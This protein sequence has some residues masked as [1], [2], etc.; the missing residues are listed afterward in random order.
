MSGKDS[1][2]LAAFCRENGHATASGIEVIR[3]TGTQRPLFLVHDIHG[4]TACGAALVQHVDVD[5]PAY[6]LLGVAPHEGLPRTIEGLAR[7]CVRLMRAL[8][9][10]DPYRVVGLSFGGILAYE[11]VVQLIGED[12]G[13]EFLG[14]ID[15][16]CPT[17]LRD[18][19]SMTSVPSI[20]KQLLNCCAENEVARDSASAIALR[21]LKSDMGG[22]FEDILRRC[23]AARI[24]PEYLNDK[25]TTQIR[26]HLARVA[27]HRYAQQHYAVQKLPIPVHVFS[28]TQDSQSLAK[29]TDPLKGW[30]AILPGDQ[31]RSIR[32]S[33]SSA[34]ML[35]PPHVAALGQAL[36]DA[37][38]EA[39]SGRLPRVPLLETAYRPHVSVQTGRR[40]RVP[41][42]CVPGAGNS[43]T[44]FTAWAQAIGEEWPVHGLQPRGLSGGLV[45]HS[46]VQAAAVQYLRAID[47]AHPHGPLHLVGHSFGG[48]IVLELAHLLRARGRPIAS[49]T[50]MDGE[51]PDTHGLLGGDYT[52]IEV[53]M[54]FVDVIEM[55]IG[56]SL[57]I[58]AFD[59]GSLD[60]VGRLHL[61]HQ[62]LVRVRKMPIR[63]KPDVLVGIVRAFGTALRTTYRPS[64][65]Y[66]DAL[67]LVTV[68]DT[69]KDENADKHRCKEQ[70]RNWLR[71]APRLSRWH[72]PGNHMTMLDRPHVT[73]LADWWRS[74]L[75]QAGQSS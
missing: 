70:V 31:L 5:M 53:L 14:L 32:V 34:S 50:V 30:D 57:G 10:N 72:G 73:V 24:L 52:A 56:Q 69:R 59:L 48:W 2:S 12:R 8:Q 17:L 63:S 38:R 21:S 18:R 19:H 26:H 1:S 66:P 15:S 3:G 22:D 67:H 13:V 35:S 75:R 23:R 39:T 51:A 45:P 37:I 7:R 58:G 46:T 47:E 40:N 68:R 25:D 33:G 41:I 74:G 20:E 55:S 44:D 64:G 4:H 36:G 71:W 6:G 27:S 42:F 16:V 49:L 29:L 62:A 60:E 61:L 28:G 65:L 43:V 54:E 9:P 11:I